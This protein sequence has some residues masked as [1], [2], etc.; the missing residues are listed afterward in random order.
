LIPARPL[1]AAFLIELDRTAVSDEDV[2]MK[3]GVPG[4]QSECWIAP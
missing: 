2:L 4:H 1:K 3:T